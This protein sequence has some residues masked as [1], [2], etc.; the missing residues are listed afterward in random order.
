MQ[1]IA[2]VVIA[3]LGALVVWWVLKVSLG[4]LLPLETTA[5]AHFLQLLKRMEIS[6]VVPPS[7]LNE[8]AAESVR[9]ARM[10]AKF[11]GKKNI[12]R[13]EMVKHLELQADMLRLWVRSDDPF[14]AVY[15][16]DF[17]I[18]FER[19]GIPRLK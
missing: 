15:K 4:L 7:C 12:V 14:D 8:C 3:I 2:Y 13:T 9:F 16:R 10:T 5:R 6:Q 19:H 18:M 1:T 11:S 17:K